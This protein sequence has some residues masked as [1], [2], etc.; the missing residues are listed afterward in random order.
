M[1]LSLARAESVKGLLVENGLAASLIETRG[2]GDSNP[3]ISCPGQQSAAVIKC[4]EPNRRMTVDV[5]DSHS[6]K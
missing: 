4:L 1:Q 2:L 6:G 3:R 5:V